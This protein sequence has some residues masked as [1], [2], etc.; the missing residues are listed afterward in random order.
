MISLFVEQ[1]SPALLCV[2]PDGPT[3]ESLLSLLRGRMEA[4]DDCINPLDL[5]EQRAVVCVLDHKRRRWVCKYVRRVKGGGV[6]A[7]IVAL[8]S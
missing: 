5:V 6:S 2:D 7:T 3:G 8:L 1:H 4:G